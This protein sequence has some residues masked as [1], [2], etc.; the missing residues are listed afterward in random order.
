MRVFVIFFAFLFQ[1]CVCQTRSIFDLVEA[2][3]EADKRCLTQFDF[4]ANAYDRQEL[5]AIQWFNS[6]AKVPAGIFSGHFESVGNFQQCIRARQ[7]SQEVGNIQGQHCMVVFRP[8]H[9]FQEVRSQFGF[10][11]QLNWGDL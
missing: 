2:S 4:I 6:W 10:T 1:F 5:W 3:T 9:E 7:S 8:K 11:D